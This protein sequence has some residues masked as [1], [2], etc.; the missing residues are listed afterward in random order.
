[1]VESM[2]HQDSQ[3]EDNLEEDFDVKLAPVSGNDDQR[4]L[5]RELFTREPIICISNFSFAIALISAGW[6]AIRLG[7]SWPLVI[8]ATIINSLMYTHLIE[9]QHECLHGHTFRSL[10]LNHLFGVSCDILMLGSYSHYCYEHLCHHVYLGT[11]QNKERFDYRSQNLNSLLGFTLAFFD[12]SRYKRVAQFALFSIFWRLLPG[13]EKE[14]YSRSIK[15]EH[16][17]NF[18]ILLAV[19][20]RLTMYC[21]SPI[22]GLA[23]WIPL[24]TISEGVH[25]LIET[26]EHLS[27]NAQANVNVLA[28]THTINTSKLVSWFVNGNDLHT[29]HHCHQGVPMCNIHKLHTIIEPTIAAVEPSYRYFY[30]QVIQGVLTKISMK[31]VWCDSLELAPSPVSLVGQ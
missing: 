6:I 27:L 28:N 22:F 30:G 17:F 4:Q 13:I 14:N 1:M 12:L 5:L 26:S 29:T 21:Q 16:L 15:L 8:L 24:L 9:L 3:L 2:R 20:V 7:L 23:W 10:R 19:S 31:H 18:I 11:T 25:F